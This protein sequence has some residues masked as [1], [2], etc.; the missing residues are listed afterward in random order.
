LFRSLLKEERGYSLIEVMVSIMILAI[1]ILPMVTMFDMGLHSATTGSH[2]DRARAL[3]NLKIE[4]AK[5]L[6]FDSSDN[7]VQD[8]N[9]NFPEA[10]GTTTTYNGSGNYQSAW[11]TQPGGNFAGFEYMI[12]K[13]YMAQ[14]PTDSDAD[15]ADPSE[16]FATST[17][18]TSLIRV[19]VTVQW[20]DGNSYT[21]F[22]LV[23]Q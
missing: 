15:P 22:G 10:A 6:P 2:Y 4:Q 20:G 1:A 7:A 13:Q 16:D 23:A 17:T 11:K 3:A 18:A 8:L 14:P 9:D 21:T 19:T 12:E 5:S